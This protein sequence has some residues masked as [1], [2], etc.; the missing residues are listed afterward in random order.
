MNRSLWIAIPALLVSGNVW[1]QQKAAP[2]TVPTNDGLSCFEDLNPAFPKAALEAHIDGSIWTWTTVS[3]QD[4][5]EKLDNEAVSAWMGDSQKFLVPAAEK[6]IHAAKIKPECAGKKVWVVFRYAL[7]GNPVPAPK[8]T[9]R[10]DGDHIL[11]IESQ[12]ETA[13]VITSKK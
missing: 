3:P 7:H 1:A 13:P 2:P 6:A 9:T 4:K 11:W 10:P 5:I 12:P 8:V